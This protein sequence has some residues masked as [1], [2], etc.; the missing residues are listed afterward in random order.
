MR[1]QASSLPFT[2]I[3]ASLV[4]IINTKL[5]LLGDLLVQRLISQFRRAY[6]R[7]DK[8]TCIATSTFLAHLVNQQVVGPTVALEIIILLLEKVTDDSVEIA[9]GFVKEV[10]AFLAESLPKAN[11]GIYARFNE[12][13]QGTEIQKRT[14]Y[15][16]EVLAEVR[17]DK[18]KD[19][20]IIPEGLDLVEEGDVITHETKL[21]DDVKVEE[22]LSASPQDFPHLTSDE[23]NR[24]TE[25][26]I[27]CA[28]DVFKYDPEFV[29]NEE[30]YDAIKRDIL[31][32]DSESESG[33]GSGSSDSTDDDDEDDDVPNT[34][35]GARRDFPSQYQDS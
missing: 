30:K 22:G 1:A 4:S 2:P 25:S 3:F 15:M 9:V 18:F 10:G 16:I 26:P 14:Q 7:N 12:V 20:P 27:C 17:R 28:P 8:P 31:G 29:E 5:P 21:Q 24:K 33:S 11:M 23:V 35:I 6:K 13:L 32:D 19:N 34:G